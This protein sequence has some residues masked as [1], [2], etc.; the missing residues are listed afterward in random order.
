[1]NRR[2]E[3]EVPAAWWAE[4]ADEIAGRLGVDPS[5]GLD[6]EHVPQMRERYGANRIAEE[7]PASTWGL[8]RESI[9]SPMMLL[10]LAIAAISLL[11]GQVREAVV[12][13]FVVLSYVGVELINKRGVS[14][15]LSP[16]LQPEFP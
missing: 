7:G 8:L 16:R 12:M 10:L 4:P 11:L 3:P 5:R 1:M 15:G 6:P 2:H 13:A 9:T 14:E